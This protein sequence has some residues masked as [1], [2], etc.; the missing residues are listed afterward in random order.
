MFAVTGANALATALI[1]SVK[2][3]VVQVWRIL[4]KEEEEKD[5]FQTFHLIFNIFWVCTILKLQLIPCHRKLVC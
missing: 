1:T 4:P 2:S 3:F 5:Q